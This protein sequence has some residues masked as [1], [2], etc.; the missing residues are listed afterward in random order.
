MLIKSF[1]PQIQ[2][3]TLNTCGILQFCVN[4]KMRA[5]SGDVLKTRERREQL[6]FNMKEFL[7]GGS[8][9]FSA[10]CASLLTHFFPLLLSLTFILHYA[11][12]GIS[13]RPGK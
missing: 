6:L 8:P 5:L 9:E 1:V 4:P 2:T 10:F 13:L 12:Y 7:F 11:A 3:R